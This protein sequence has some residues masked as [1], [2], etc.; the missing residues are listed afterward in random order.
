MHKESIAEEA[1]SMEVHKNKHDY[2]VGGMN[3]SY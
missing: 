1:M 3:Q 2:K